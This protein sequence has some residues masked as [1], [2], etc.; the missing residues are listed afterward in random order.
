M[1]HGRIYVGEIK[2]G[3]MFQNFPE[4]FQVVSPGKFSFEKD[5]IKELMRCETGRICFLQN[6][7]L[8]FSPFKLII[9]IKIFAAIK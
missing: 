3:I 2:S 7:L 9:K 6:C 4:N 8:T 5:D 1:R